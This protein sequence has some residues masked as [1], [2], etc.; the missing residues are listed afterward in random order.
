MMLC[1]DSLLE[2]AAGP[3]V[4]VHRLFHK[5]PVF[6]PQGILRILI[7]HDIGESNMDGFERLLGY[8]MGEYDIV[9]PAQA[10]EIL[11]NKYPLSRRDSCLLT[12][13]D[14]FSSNYLIAQE[15]L[16]RY[17]IKALFFICPGLM[18]TPALGQRDAIIRHLFN[19]NVEAF[20]LEGGQSLMSWQQVLS[21]ARM[22]HT[23][24]SHTLYHARLSLLKPKDQRVE[25][26]ESAD[27]LEDK[28]GVPV[29]WFAYPFGDINS[30]DA[31]AMELIGQRYNF[32]CSGVRGP[33]SFK[34]HPLGLLREPVNLRRS[35]ECQKLEAGGG[36]DF[37]YRLRSKRLR[38]VMPR[39]SLT[40][41]GS[42]S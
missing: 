17:G 29:R 42:R 26:M 16:G 18:D 27:R 13:D 33:N 5:M 11:A 10:Q 39:R 19:N 31:S 30:I 20:F 3:C 37:L 8:L 6:R 40:E 35:F 22:G 1:K 38:D 28:L 36:L 41:I 25:I 24:G 4:R 34:T 15:L 23:I 2:L 14:G 32:C 12:L 21:L 7:L 9:S